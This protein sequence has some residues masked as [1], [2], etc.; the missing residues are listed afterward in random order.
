MLEKPSK[1]YRLP[2]IDLTRDLYEMLEDFR[3]SH[4]NPP[5]KSD[6]V[7]AALRE[8]IEKRMKPKK[9]TTK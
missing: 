2:T 6:V 1:E 7:R 3:E 4:E 5:S 9:R 8:F